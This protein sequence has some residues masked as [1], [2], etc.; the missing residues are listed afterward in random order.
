MTLPTRPLGIVA[1]AA[2]A[3]LLAIPSAA[4]ARAGDRTYQETYPVASKLCTEVAAGK[5]PR[6]HRFAARIQADCAALQAGFT[7][8]QADVL[9]A[10]TTL[11][12]AIAADRAAIAAACPPPMV[13]HPPCE[14]VRDSEDPA[15]DVLHRQ[16]VNAARRYFRVV[17]AH[18]RVFW[19]DIHAIGVLRHL[20]ADLPIAQHDN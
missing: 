15:I 4:S 11:G 20:Q 16:L 14:R 3:A 13:G 1:L 6:L 10:R 18:R 9:A 5:R 7:V 8:A 2:T 12:A 17:E 19:R